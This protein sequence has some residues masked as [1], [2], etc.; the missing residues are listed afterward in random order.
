M[1]IS[2]QLYD[3]SNFIILENRIHSLKYQ[4]ATTLGSLDLGIRKLE[5]VA[6]PQFL[7]KMISK[8]LAN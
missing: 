5:F 3:L 1:P 7:Y 6:K 8:L 2:L 4:M